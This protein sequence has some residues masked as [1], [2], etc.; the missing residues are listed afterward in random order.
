MQEPMDETVDELTA[1]SYLRSL[2]D[3]LTSGR[4]SL[5]HE[6]TFLSMTSGSR[7]RFRLRA[8]RDHGHESVRW[9]V[10]DAPEES[11]E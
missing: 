8:R 4:L 3:A 5:L 1:R 6:D 10:G 11:D 7:V 2:T 9:K